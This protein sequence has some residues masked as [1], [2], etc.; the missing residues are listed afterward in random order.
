M[1]IVAEHL[2]A[3]GLDLYV[4]F[5]ADGVTPTNLDYPT[6]GA[7]AALVIGRD[8]EDRITRLERARI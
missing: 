2:L 1:G 8:H 5:E 6:F 7:Y 3:A 4:L